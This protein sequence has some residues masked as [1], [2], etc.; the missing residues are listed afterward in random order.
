MHDQIKIIKF[1]ASGYRQTNARAAKCTYFSSHDRYLER[2]SP[3]VSFYFDVTG[4]KGETEG[5][6]FPS[7][8]I[9]YQTR[10]MGE[11][12]QVLN[13]CQDIMA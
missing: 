12:F 11:Q 4:A 9:R 13:S 1:C 6:I 7:F 5:W 2:Y 3:G 10:I 8:S